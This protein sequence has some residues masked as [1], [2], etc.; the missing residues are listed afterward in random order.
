MPLSTRGAGYTPAPAAGSPQPSRAA[1][2]GPRAA[3][4]RGAGRSWYQRHVATELRAT[5]CNRDCPDVCR[6]L[7]HVEVEGGHERVVRLE[8]D[9]AHP[10]TRGS[11]CFRT[12]RFL[13]RQYSPERLTSPLLRKG[14]ELVPVSW[15]EALDFVAA[16]LL[17]IRAES[18]PAAILHYRSGGSLGLLTALSDHLFEQLGPVTVKRGDICSGAGDYAQL[19]DFGEEDSHA[20]E[21]LENARHI[22]LWGKNVVVSSPHTLPVLKRAQAK[23]AELVLIDPVHHKTA[24]HADHYVQPRPG[25]DFALA[26]AV[27]QVLFA[28]GWVDPTAAEYCDHVPEFRALA[29]SR[30]LADWCA[31]AD[32]SP[33]VAHDLARRLGPGQPTAILVGWGM[34]RRVNGAAIVRALDA[35]GAI[36]GN[37]GRPGGGVSFYFKR[38]GAFDT[39]FVRGAEVA[40][41]SVAEPLLGREILEAQDPPIRAVWITCGN[42]VAMLPD[43]TTTARA[44]ETREL[45][46]VVDSFLTDTAARATVVLPTTTLLEA[47]DL[48]GSYGHHYLGVARPVVA[49]PP[50][51]RPELEILQALAA[52]LGLSHVLEG[53]ARAWKRRLIEPKLGPHGVTLEALEA[54]PVLNP[55]PPKVL[56]ADRRFPTPSG[57]VQLLTTPPAP[58]QIADGLVLMS[59]STEKSQAAQ[60]AVAPRAHLPCT[61]HPDVAAAAGVAAGEVATLISSIGHMDVQVVVDA[62][63]RRDVALV[64]KGGHLARGQCA[65]AL[66]AARTT[67]HGEGG[68]LYDE[69]VRLVPRGAA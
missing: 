7:A 52:R 16:G 2:A 20:L 1:D 24:H 31:E 39:S 49:P 67:D 40:P 45:V 8:G 53:D 10:I 32:V 30:S 48:L 29:E 43:S 11:L 6:I 22:L 47:D 35:L 41:R 68:A 26:M 62:R 38:R 60:W 27:A 15:D 61:V 17:R 18:G 19:A 46:V 4:A 34:G 57:R 36:S 33:T 63:Q 23:G 56:F 42:P 51:V 44:L 37:L 12:S 59:L 50:G 64:P 28:E 13:E 9:P 3:G 14:G 65:N 54:G 58:T 5:T 21:D 25:G 55:L 69:R 66:V